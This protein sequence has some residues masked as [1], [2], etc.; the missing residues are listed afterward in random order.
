MLAPSLPFPPHWAAGI[1]RYEFLRHLSERHDVSLLTYV[2]ADEVGNVTALAELGITVHPVAAPPADRRDRRLAQL[3]SVWSTSSYAARSIFSAAMKEAVDRLI[4]SGG[5]DVVIIETCHMSG[6]DLGPHAISVLDEHNIESEL[7]F[8]G[9]LTEGGPFRRLFNL[10]ESVKVRRE[11]RAAWRRATACLVHSDRERQIL[12][13]KVPGKRAAVVTNGV[14]LDEFRIGEEPPDRNAIVFTGAM[15]YRPN[16]DAVTFFVRQVFPLILDQRP[17]AIFYAVGVGPPPELR[18]LAG[19]NVV[20]TGRVPD[21]KP[22]LRKA[23]VYVAPVRFGSGTRI[24]VI[25]ALAAGRPIVSTTL[26]CEGH[27]SMLAGVHFLAAD[28]AATFARQVLR[29][30]EDRVLASEL[31][32]A[33]RNLVEREYS[34]PALLSRLDDFLADVVPAMERVES[35]QQSARTLT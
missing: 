20:I 8:R 35:H 25:E 19:P 32:Q 30:L 17:D 22:Y 3:A 15:N 6:F 16:T 1:R 18:R 27:D 21:V 10:I 7:L 13:R 29:V 24:K 9:F 26:G 12:L 2:S 31:G 11:E 34:W 28:D 5:F 33:G 4:K 23:S 14:H